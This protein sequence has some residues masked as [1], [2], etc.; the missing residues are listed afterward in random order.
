MARVRVHSFGLSL[1]GFSAGPDQSLQHPLGVGGPRLMEWFM[2][3]RV[4]RNMQGQEGGETGKFHAAA[5]ARTGARRVPNSRRM[6][7]YSM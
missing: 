7:K 1:D 3:T 5:T 4:W 6:P 2:A